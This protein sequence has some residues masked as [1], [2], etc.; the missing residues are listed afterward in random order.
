MNDSQFTIN[1]R[2][3]IMG[4]WKEFSS[5]LCSRK[6]IN[7]WR[8]GKNEDAADKFHNG[9]EFGEVINSRK[10]YRKIQQMVL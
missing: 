5:F 2:S 6:E 1:L 3:P 9:S 8:C 7:S 10:D 4:P